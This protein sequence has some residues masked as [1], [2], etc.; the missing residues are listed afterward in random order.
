MKWWPPALLLFAAA[1]SAV[2]VISLVLEN[3]MA[4]GWSRNEPMVLGA[5][6]TIVVA[7]LTGLLLP[8]KLGA[9]P[10]RR[11]LLIATA[12]VVI[13]GFV[14]RIVVTGQKQERAAAQDAREREHEAQLKAGI[15]AR[16]RD[17]ESRIAA[18]QVYSPDA[19]AALVSF[20][21]GTGHATR[22]A[23]TLSADAIAVLQRALEGKLIDPNMIVKDRL[24]ADVGPEPLFVHYHRRIRQAPERSVLAR[25]WRIM[26]LLARGADLSLPA[27]APVAAD[28]RKTATPLYG[29]L[30][31]D[32][33]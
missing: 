16:K 21:H 26:L 28:L 20:V 29:G 30:Y 14:P 31:F 5:L 27:A 22:N 12:L 15:A 17:V 10:A 19:A 18:A 8:L 3:L 33:K 9:G 7:A 1:A 4:P 2:N 25:D 6:A 23:E 11:W 32:L 24:R 13:A